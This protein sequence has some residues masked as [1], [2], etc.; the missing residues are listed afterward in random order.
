MKR[1]IAALCT[2]LILL[3][4]SA[5]S[6]TCKYEMSHG[7][8]D[9]KATHGDYCSTHSCTYCDS[10]ITP[11]SAYCDEHRCQYSDGYSR[12]ENGIGITAK[13]DGSIYC[14]EHEEIEDIDAFTEAKKIAST[15][16]NTVAA[17]AAG[18]TFSPFR[19]TGEF[20]IGTNA[21]KFEVVDIDPPYRDGYVIVELNSDGVL[22][23]KGMQYN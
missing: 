2:L 7:K 9:K 11:G 14:K 21:Y 5:C 8:C 18:S 12:C 15:W 10:P 13:Q 1:L 3:F 4:T 19:F 17:N 6:S 16:C 23:C 20:Y 22:E